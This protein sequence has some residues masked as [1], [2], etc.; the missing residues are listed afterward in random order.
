M[1]SSKAKGV[2]GTKKTNQDRVNEFA[3]DLILFG[4]KLY[5]KWC[6]I[7]IMNKHSSIVDHIKP[8]TKHDKTKKAAREKN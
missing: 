7:P 1:A 4:E 2:K 8:N 3:D 5:C 6:N